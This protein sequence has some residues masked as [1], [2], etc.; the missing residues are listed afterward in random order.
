M[1]IYDLL[2]ELR[3]S[4]LQGISTENGTG[5]DLGP[6]GAKV[7][8]AVCLA[9]VVAAGGTLTL[10]LQGSSDNVT[11]YDIPGTDFLTPASGAVISAVGSYEVH[12]VTDF[13]YIRTKGVVAV[14]AVTWEAF[15]TKSP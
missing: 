15:V 8:K 13:R 3:A 12:F 9:S 2:C 10:N 14:A 1:S 6:V 7:V 11:F 5:K 4:S